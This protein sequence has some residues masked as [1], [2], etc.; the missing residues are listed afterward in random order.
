[1]QQRQG[2]W[3]SRGQLPQC[4]VVKHAL[5]LSMTGNLRCWL[6]HTLRPACLAAACL[7]AAG[8]A[9]SPACQG[10]FQGVPAHLPARPAGLAYLDINRGVW[11]LFCLRRVCHEGHGLGGG[12][13]RVDSVTAR[14]Q[15]GSV[16]QSCCQQCEPS[17][18]PRRS[19]PPESNVQG[20]PSRRGAAAIASQVSGPKLPGWQLGGCC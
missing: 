20:P 2:A 7:A 16:P 9:P 12:T 17:G 1:M 4:A 10:G 5:P 15:P 11:L 6:P 13:A 14:Q 19:S 8:P 3:R 18:Q